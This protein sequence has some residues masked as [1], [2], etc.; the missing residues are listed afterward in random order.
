[1]GVQA[2]GRKVFFVLLSARVRFFPDKVSSVGEKWATNPETWSSTLN[3]TRSMDG[4]KPRG[5]GVDCQ[6][7]R[8]EFESR[9]ECALEGGD[10]NSC[11]ERRPRLYKES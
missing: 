3:K 8:R 5:Q 4:V 9:G 7:G 1:M 10:P 6:H 2:E 11:V